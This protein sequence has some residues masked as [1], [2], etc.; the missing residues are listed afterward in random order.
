MAELPILP[1]KTDALLADTS[2]MSA[3]EFG[4]YCRILLVMWRHGARL[5]DNEEELARIAGVPLSRW[6]KMAEKVRRP[7]TAAGGV[8]SQKRLT[9]TWLRV[10]EVRKKRALAAETR[11]SAKGDPP[12]NRAPPPGEHM[13]MHVQSTWNANQ[14]QKRRLLTSSESSA[15]RATPAGRLKIERIQQAPE[16]EE[17]PQG[18]PSER[19]GRDSEAVLGAKPAEKP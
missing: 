8:L 12:R 15:A 9:D 1:L 2:H 3:A 14:T 18:P 7:L 13:H 19:A 5:P 17:T 16:P 10:H 6:R 4:A 11:W